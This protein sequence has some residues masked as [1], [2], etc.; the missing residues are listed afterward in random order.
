MKV[1]ALSRFHFHVVRLGLP[2][3]RPIWNARYSRDWVAR[4]WSLD[5]GWYRF[6]LIRRHA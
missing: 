5:L 3:G 6:V 2:H 4:H 1:L